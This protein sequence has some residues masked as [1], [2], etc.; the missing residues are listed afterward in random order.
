MESQTH[1][2]VIRAPI[3]VCFD[4]LVDSR[5]VQTMAARESIGEIR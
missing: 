4:T 3:D 1:T 5:A 2:E